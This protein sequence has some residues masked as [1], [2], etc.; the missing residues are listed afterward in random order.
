MDLARSQNILLENDMDFFFSQ[1]CRY[2]AAAIMDPA[3]TSV[4]G[5]YLACSVKQNRK[6]RLCF[7]ETGVAF[8][9]IVS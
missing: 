9:S 3:K 8:S 7:P 5:F 4:R 1:I 6:K 2:L